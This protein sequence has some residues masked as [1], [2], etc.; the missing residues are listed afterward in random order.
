MKPDEEPNMHAPGM[1]PTKGPVMLTPAQAAAQKAAAQ[2][3][4]VLRM[5]PRSQS[6]VNG[7]QTMMIPMGQK[8][9]GRNRKD[10]S[11]RTSIGRA[12]WQPANLLYPLR[13]LRKRYPLRNRRKTYR[14]PQRGGTLP[15]KNRFLLHSR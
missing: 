6:Q 4:K 2:A 1:D 11:G 3:M 7:V 8:T 15:R 9:S 10:T 14:L 12:S 13:N 5:P